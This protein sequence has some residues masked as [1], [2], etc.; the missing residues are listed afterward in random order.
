[1]SESE[2]RLSQLDEIIR[3]GLADSR[4]FLVDLRRAI[5]KNP[6]LRYEEF[7]TA[8]RLTQ[9]MR[10]LGL[11]VRE[12]LGVTGL[13][14]T[15][16]GQAPPQSNVQVVAL[17]ADMDALPLQEETGLPFASENPGVMHACGHDAHS[18]IVAT[19]ARVAAQ[20]PR[21][22]E[23]LPG[24][25][26]FLFQPAEE[27]GLG[28]QAMIDA[29]ALENPSI[30]AMLGLHV[31]PGLRT[32]EISVY[33]SYSHASADSFT[34]TFTGKGGHAG[35]PHQSHDPI[36]PTA[37]WIVAI[38]SLVAREVDPLSP[39]VLSVGS[40]HGGHTFNVTPE[41]ITLQGTL[42]CL[43]EEERDRIK[44]RM[45]ELADGFAKAHRAEAA[46]SFEA[47]CPAT[48]N[49]ARISRVFRSQA[50]PLLG[51]QHVH[52]LPPGMGAEDFGI[53]A[54]HLPA[55]LFR[56]GCTPKTA[57]EW[58]PLHSP[59]FYVDEESLFLAAEILL[60]SALR[61]LFSG[62]PPASREET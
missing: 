37:D 46:L 7:A 50:E 32:G 60:K 48:L 2:N 55:A 6:E 51:A 44:T 54:K 28:A 24:K 25:L 30:D 57:K 47:E 42:R 27:G 52:A 39:A 53:Y 4:E 38:R 16:E 15:L 10:T 14:A 20:S 40:I 49:D 33:E 12:G 3:E 29:G 11:S 1:M 18:A 13:T 17:R 22:R 56:L 19:M 61:L 5:H 31:Y 41:S 62:L 59:H 43:N 8:S 26:V 45:R 36:S 35:Y 21:L 58:F 34:L 9:E 23:L